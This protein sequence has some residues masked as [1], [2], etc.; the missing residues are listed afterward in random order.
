MKIQAINQGGQA[1]SDIEVS[2]AVFACAFNEL[3]VHQAVVSYQA[4]GRQ[5][6]RAQKTRAQ[7]RGGGT[8]PWRQ[9]GTGRARA[10][11]IR[12]PLWRGGGKTFP[13]SPG[14]R[15]GKKLNRKMHRGALRA[16]LSEL[17]R[18]G[19]LTV[20]SELKVAEPKTKLLVDVLDKLNAPDALIVTEADERNLA[21][22][23]RNLPRVDVR[24]VA[25]ADPVA[26]LRHAKVIATPQ[27]LKRFEEI[28]R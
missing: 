11:T 12:S 6:T 13:S 26:L 10:G 4:N 24:N 16:I 14:E 8:K 17:L 7:A 1:G 23:A 5:G 20:L 27:A 19:R 28:L 21:L 18:S 15:F 22:A 3:L 9:K 2:D 25:S